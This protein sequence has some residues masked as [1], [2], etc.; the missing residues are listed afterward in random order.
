MLASL[1]STALLMGLAGG[2]H[3]LAM[4]AA[5][6]SVVT[7]TAQARAVKFAWSG[8]C[9]PLQSLEQT[10]EQF[11]ADDANACP[12]RSFKSAYCSDGARTKRYIISADGDTLSQNVT[13]KKSR[14]PEIAAFSANGAWSTM[15]I[16]RELKGL[17]TG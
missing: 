8:H 16:N 13:L 2:P 17:P 10:I 3:C 5:P 4:C 9:C 15:S 7:G 14:R 12:S 11:R 1:A 6:C